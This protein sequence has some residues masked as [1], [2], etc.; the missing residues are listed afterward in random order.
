MPPSQNKKPKLA[1]SAKNKP[2]PKKIIQYRPIRPKPNSFPQSSLSGRTFSCNQSPSTSS[3]QIDF[4]IALQGM[5]YS[6]LQHKEHLHLKSP[7]YPLTAPL[8]RKIQQQ[9]F[10][11]DSSALSH[12]LDLLNDSRPNPYEY[13]TSN[14]PHSCCSKSTADEKL[15]YNMNSLISPHQES[16]SLSLSDTWTKS[17]L[18]DM[19]KTQDDHDSDLEAI[20]SSIPNFDLEDYLNG[21]KSIEDL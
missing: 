5:D 21:S 3:P 10:Q 4:P 17:P 2:R 6:T 19:H 9:A 13:S 7:Y 11:K 8:D 20:V 15:I 1:E 12:H 14:E 16:I 18:P